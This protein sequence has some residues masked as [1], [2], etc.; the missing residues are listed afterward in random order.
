MEI[1]LARNKMKSTQDQTSK[2]VKIRL[3]T[4]IYIY[5]CTYIHTHI[6]THTYIHIYIHTHTHKHTHVYI[7]K[8]LF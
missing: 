4:Y 5:I 7:N 2:G 1:E 6:Y 3:I 8:N